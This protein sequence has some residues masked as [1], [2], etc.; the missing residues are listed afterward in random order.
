MDYKKIFKS[1][2][3]RAKIL[4]FLRFVPD[5]LMV[6]LQYWIK[7]GRRLDLKHPQRFTE[8]L[9]WY[10]LRYRNP[11]MVACVDKFDVRAYVEECGLK[12]ILT[13][14]YGVFDNGDEIDFSR[15]PRSF[16]L[17][18]TLGGGGNAVILVE[19]KEQADLEQIR[20]R[21]NAW[22]SNKPSRS[23]GREWPY[24][25]GKSHRIIAE[26]YLPS[27]PDQG[28]LIEYKFFCFNGK[29]TF[30]YV[31]ADRAVGKRVSLAIYDREFNKVPYLRMDEE[32]LER[33]IEK[34]EKYEDIPRIG[35]R[36]HIHQ[37]KCGNIPGYH[38]QCDDELHRDVLSQ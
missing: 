34:P 8:K 6:R 25:E 32:P 19:D 27:D 11:L 1:R 18:D 35:R 16:V 28:G 33:D 36:R 37:H 22:T 17:K 12:D 4:R 14:C 30:S 5:E 13:T 9:Q 38:N 7:M 21:L 26:E 29:A 20:A 24:Y 3:T 15:L 10:K 23:G 2:Q 31:L